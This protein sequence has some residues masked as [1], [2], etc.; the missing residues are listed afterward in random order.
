MY[1]LEKKLEK[2]LKSIYDIE[3][4]IGK[5][6]LETENGRDLIS[7]KISIKNSFRNSKAFTRKFNILY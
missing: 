3:R 4:I 1:F 6:I 7:L 2:K 5:L